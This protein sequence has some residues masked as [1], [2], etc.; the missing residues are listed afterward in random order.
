MAYDDY[1]GDQ[2]DGEPDPA[3]SGWKLPETRKYN[4]TPLDEPALIPAA[5]VKPAAA[6]VKPITT[7][8][9]LLGSLS[10]AIQSQAGRAVDGFNKAVGV[11]TA[12]P[13]YQAGVLK[14]QGFQPADLQYTAPD[15]TAPANLFY[16]TDGGKTRY[17]I[18]GVKGI[19]G[20]AGYA[21]FQ[22]QRKG[23]GSFSV[24]PGLSDGEKQQYAEIQDRERQARQ[25]AAML[26]HY[27]EVASR[28]GLTP[29]QIVRLLSADTATDR[30]DR[31]LE[32]KQNQFNQRLELD[33]DRLD[34]AKLTA[35]ERAKRSNEWLDFQRWRSEQSDKRRAFKAGKKRNDDL[36]VAAPVVGDALA[37]LEA[38]PGAVM[39]EAGQAEN[40]GLEPLNMA[41]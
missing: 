14:R 13:D 12:K 16:K 10:S 32:S 20:G 15:N 25:S 2:F 19:G 11:A 33:N 18:P 40:V 1:Q 30:A 4:M 38:V 26:N 9:G 31:A 36:S 28:L 7:A 35:Q 22:G 17:E 5:S 8:G 27:S 3:G 37:A 34:F 29:N 23:G 6:P 39:M 41:A 24:I 21:E